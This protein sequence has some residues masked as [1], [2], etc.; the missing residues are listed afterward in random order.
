[1]RIFYIKKHREEIDLF[2]KMGYI[3]CIGFE[4]VE[5][6]VKELLRSQLI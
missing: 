2:Y 3:E 5:D 6:E 1:M 4:T